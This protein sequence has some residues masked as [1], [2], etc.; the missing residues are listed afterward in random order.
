MNYCPEKEDPNH[1][2][3]TVGGNLVHYPGNCGTPT[4]NM[5]TVKL[6]LISVISTKNVC[7][8]TINLKDFYLNTPIPATASSSLRAPGALPLTC[9]FNQT[10]PI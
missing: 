8:C 2:Q 4:V 1:T 6:H 3:V 5:V 7:Y 9:I 10:F